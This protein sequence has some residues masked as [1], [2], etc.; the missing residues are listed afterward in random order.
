MRRKTLLTLGAGI[1]LLAGLANLGS[2]ILTVAA[3]ET[4]W[5]ASSTRWSV[6]S[7]SW[8][9]RRPPLSAQRG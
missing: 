3:H 7:S 2:A 6:G 5:P 1:A 9:W 8:H 4:T